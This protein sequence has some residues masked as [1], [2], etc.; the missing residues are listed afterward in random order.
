MSET[1]FNAT[2]ASLLI[3]FA[4]A[5]PAQTQTVEISAAPACAVSSS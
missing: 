1:L 4:A 5:A 3:A 2:F